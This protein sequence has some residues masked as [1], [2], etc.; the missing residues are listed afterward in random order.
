MSKIG[1]G[2]GIVAPWVAKRELDEGTLVAIPTGAEPIVREWS[3]FWNT[4][5]PLSLIEETFAGI[6]GM[7]GE[8]LAR[9]GR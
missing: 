6:S 2:I 7:V 8:D 1:L 4:D 5:R 9:L 3:I